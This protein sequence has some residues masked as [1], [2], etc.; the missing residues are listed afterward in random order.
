MLIQA[1]E[2]DTCRGHYNNVSCVMFHPR[3]ELILSN[4]EDK[5]IRVWDMAKRICLHTF[6]REHDR[7]WVLAAHP[8]L[9]LFAAGH[10]SGMI[11]FKVGR[12]AFSSWGL[13][14]CWCG[15][16][17]L[18]PD[19]RAQAAV[20]FNLVYFKLCSLVMIC[21]Q[22]MIQTYSL[23]TDLLI[24]SFVASMAHSGQSYCS[25]GALNSITFH[26]FRAWSVLL[27][28]FIL[29]NPYSCKRMP[30]HSFVC[31]RIKK[32]LNC[33]LMRVFE[34]WLKQTTDKLW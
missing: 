16:N 20:L 21:T 27:N 33:F 30:P 24:V 14:Q 26:T 31:C 19:L 32:Q 28:K 6:R 17:V 15:I 25:K 11:I 3:Q 2:V 8:S 18:H 9:N 34:I 7:F 12:R 10:D 29:S 1:W 22:S 4:S 13:G 23:F 5:S